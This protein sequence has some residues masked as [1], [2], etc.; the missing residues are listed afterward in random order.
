LVVRSEAVDAPAFSIQ[1]ERDGARLLLSGAWITSTVK[2]VDDALR[3]FAAPQARR[4]TVD[5]EQVSA[6]DTAG[7]WLVYRTMKALKGHGAQVEL[8]GVGADRARLIEVVAANERVMPPDHRH[9]MILIQ[10]LERIGT[11]AVEFWAALAALFAFF[12]LTLE[13]LWKIILNPG[14][15]RWNAFTNTI[16]QAGINAVPIISLMSFLVGAVIAYQGATQLRNFGADVLTVDLVSVSVLREFG[17]LLTAIMVAGRSGSAYAAEIGAMRV[18]EEVD[19]MRALALDPM[20]I[21]V[22]PRILGLVI[23][24]PLLNF[25]SD[26][27]GLA[28][29][30]I[31]TWSELGITPQAFIARLHEVTFIN[32]FWAGMIKAP[33]FGY[34]V[35]MIGCYE[36]FRVEGSAES[37]GRHTTLSVVES[38]FIVIV[39]D[40]FFSVFFMQVHI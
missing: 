30:C 1:A 6:F 28:G 21:L 16:E 7:A 35:A 10:L 4:V 13:T 37:V 20:E 18:N 29:G 33:I 23:A 8:A 14:R 25:I 15:F 22:M 9:P 40:A 27:A 5:L 24:M 12:G 39:V 36:G 31:A 32:N 34:L 3:H 26:I 38:I 11:G 19:A 17:I 2:A